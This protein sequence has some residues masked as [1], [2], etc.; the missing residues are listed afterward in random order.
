MK[1][2]FALVIINFIAV[3]ILLMLTCSLVHVGVVL[4][5][6]SFLLPSDI[7]PLEPFFKII[8]R[9]NKHLSVVVSRFWKS[10]GEKQ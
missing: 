9:Q 5:S 4:F 6:L 2:C 1:V 3:H 10:M 8:N 7:K